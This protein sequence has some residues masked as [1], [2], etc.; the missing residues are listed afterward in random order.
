MRFPFWR[1]RNEELDE[2][3][4]NHLRMSAKDRQERGESV[5]EATKSAR[6]EIGNTA[7]V[8]ET[9]RNMWGWTSLERLWQDLRFGARVLAKQRAFTL[10]AVL[11][12]ALGIGANTAIFSVVNA[13]LLQPL[14]Y[15]DS[16]RLV[17]LFSSNEKRG[18][19]ESGISAP[20]F[21]DLRTQNEIF[22]QI[23]AI[24]TTN[25]NLTDGQPERVVASVVSANFFDT[26]GVAPLIGRGFL[27]DEEQ[28]GHQQVVVLSYGLWERRFGSDRSLVGK[29]VRLNGQPY[30]VAGVMPANFQFAGRRDAWVPLVLD[31][32]IQPWRADRGNRG[33]LVIGKLKPEITAA[34]SRANLE[35]SSRRFESQYPET[36]A[37]WSIH[38]ITFYD[39]IIPAQVR[40]VFWVLFGSVG[41]VLLITCANVANLLLAR[42]MIRQKEVAVRSA[43]GASAGRIIR[44][45]LSESCLLALLGGASGLLLAW[46]GIK[47]FVK[48]ARAIAPR[49]T[50][51]SINGRVLWFTVVVSLVTCL[52]F[53]LIPALQAS[54]VNLNDDFKETSRSLIG[55][56]SHRVRNA[57]VVVEIGLALVLLTGAGLMVQSFAKLERV[58]LGF[59]PEK[60]L[61]MQ[62][63]LPQPQYRDRVQQNTFYKQALDGI[64]TLPGVID[65]S[66]VVGLPLSG[67]KWAMEI[68]IEGR[69]ATEDGLSAQAAAVM[70]HYFTS[71]SI[72]LI[73]GRD[74]TEQ[75][76]PDATNIIVSETTARRFWPNENPLGKRFRPGTNNPL[77]TIVGV[78]GDVHAVSL[79]E[80]YGPAIYFS[81]AQLGFNSMQL[82]IH[83]NGEP[84]TA[85]SAVRSQINTLDKNL[86]IYNV[87]TMDS[88]VTDILGQPRFNAQLF[89]L[90]A[91]VALLLAATGIYGVISYSV[92][93]RT[94]EIGIRLALGAQ[95]RDVLKMVIGQGLKLTLI[96]L[97]VG[98][99]GALAL[100]RL[101]NS[102]LFGI[103]ATDPVTFTG[104]PILLIL[105][106]LLACWIP[107]R[108]ATK[109]DPLI[110]LRYE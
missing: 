27:S 84:E 67:T 37:A 30:L 94:P 97:G 8:K 51:A 104:I 41:F 68:T 38:A 81:A 107:A 99:V 108:R 109:V 88:Y 47:L 56:F 100:T 2:E 19:A 18:L 85:T 98:V 83:T 78:V 21:K 7:L 42:A 54:R 89:S 34:E 9:T 3:I 44:Q 26:L 82:V 53:G 102:L 91:I 15:Q 63:A 80:E 24:E 23:T 31:A 39:W 72:P 60:V 48:N 45:F 11:T 16:D 25:F 5:E 12:L 93:Q 28:S 29:T 69:A 14:P 22:D 92:T 43:L 1:R 55:G 75:D 77:M 33:L 64:R 70:P 20:D 95:I 76:G 110:A 4:N 90:F 73:Q 6:R 52:L 87:R 49:L 61:T 46:S 96:G 86:P 59:N 13:V 103:S 65:A 50:D 105:V 66:A 36:N 106:A 62:I 57:L 71:I 10:T 40:R 74:F 79:D 35:L 58:K 101:L 32:A 17:R